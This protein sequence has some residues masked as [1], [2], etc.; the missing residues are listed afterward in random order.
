MNDAVTTDTEIAVPEENEILTEN[1]PPKRGKLLAN[2]PVGLRI[3]AIVA[4][5]MLAT[6]G[7]GGKIVYEN[8]LL[9]KSA[10][11]IVQISEIATR[12]SD[13][14]H[15]LTS[16]RGLTSRYIDNRGKKFAVE[17]KEARTRVDVSLAELRSMFAATDFGKIG[18][19]TGERVSTLLERL[20]LLSDHREKIDAMGHTTESGTK[21]YSEL[22]ADEIDTIS[23]MTNATDDGV[24]LR[25]MI[26][27]V[28]A[29]KAAEY[30]GQERALG[31]AVISA[32]S[33][34]PSEI[35]KFISL[36]AKQEIEFSVFSDTA[37]PAVAALL[38]S[39]Q[40]SAPT[41]EFAKMRKMMLAAIDS[42][43]FDGLTSE[44][45]WAAANNRLDALRQLETAVAADLSA[46]SVR[47]Q[48]TAFRNFAIISAL[49]VALIIGVSIVAILVARSVAR[50]VK[51][52]TEITERL[53]E[54]ALDTEIDIAESRD[55]IGRLVTQVKIFKDGLVKNKVLER[56]QAEAERKRMEAERKAEEQR[57]AAETRAAEEQTAA[58]RKASEDQRVARLELAESFERGI[59]SIIDGVSAAAAEMQASSQSMAATAEQAS[60]QSTAAAAATE[61]ASTNVQTVAAAAEE[62]SASI[63]EISRQVSKSTDIA[64][65]AV[66]RAEVTNSKVQGLSVSAQKI[67]EVVNL[68]NDIASQ[69]NLLALNATIE[70]ARA[71]EAGKGFAVVATEVKSLADQTAKATEEIGGQIGEIQLATAEAVDAIR[72]ISTVIGDINDI[73]GSIAAAVEEQGA[74]TQEIS[75]SV[76]QAALGTQ[77]VSS[78]MVSMTEATSETGSSAGE[79]HSAAEELSVQAEKLKASVDEFLKTLRAA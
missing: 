4:L 8:Y 73:A 59:G 32:M 33:F 24:A 79:V 76:Q 37:G 43:L 11:K 6:I 25:R 21:F 56:S 65:S 46:T 51:R 12:I 17:M 2:I 75:H 45:W 72:E 36:G 50:P 28:A 38:D 39:F 7:F 31:T 53:A 66:E 58:T 1:S 20:G 54:G 71:G 42:G 13:T 10:L 62:L 19:N 34:N 40:Q 52:L 3:A 64:R 14:A 49:V 30:S 68:I 26:P 9:Q 29:I 67:G 27:Y 15:A 70:A 35:Q 61:E 47:T 22:I 16:E 44:N 41:V 78:N 5:P 57:L 63:Q 74:S 60:S 18:P 77:E 23:A 48:Q 69:T 55:E